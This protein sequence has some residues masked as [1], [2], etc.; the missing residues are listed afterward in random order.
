MPIDRPTSYADLRSRLLIK[1]FLDGPDGRAW[2]GVFG[3]A[4]DEELDRLYQAK[5]VRY[6][7]HCPTDALF[8]LAAER[9]LERVPQESEAQHRARLRDA[10]GIWQRSGSQAIHVESLGWTGLLNVHVYRRHEWSTPQDV[11]SVN[12]KAFARSVWSQFDVLVNR[13]HPWKPV[14]WGDGHTW[15]QGWTWGSTATEAEIAL[16]KRLIRQHKAAHDTGTYLILNLG[17]G[18][19]WGDWIWGDGGLWGGAGAGPLAIVVGEPHWYTRGL[20]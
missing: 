7:N 19:V 15:G 8:Y 6:P 5:R 16:L 3:R 17:Y 10:W 1:P 14:Y 12:V 2:Q 4:M 20:A 13:P 11:G 18:R 9:G